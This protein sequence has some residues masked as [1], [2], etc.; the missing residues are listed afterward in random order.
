MEEK[1]VPNFSNYNINIIQ[2]L[3]NFWTPQHAY[4]IW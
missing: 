1:G 4:K 3:K 2:N